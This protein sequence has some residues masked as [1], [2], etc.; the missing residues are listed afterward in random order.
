M[1]AARLAFE[2]QFVVGHPVS[3]VLIRVRNFRLLHTRA[4]KTKLA[5]LASSALQRE[6]ISFKVLDLIQELAANRAILNRKQYIHTT[7]KGSK[8]GLKPVLALVGTCGY[9]HTH[10]RIP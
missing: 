5:W 3:H 9:P 10:M 1:H 8:R 7:D 6:V 2:R 4:N